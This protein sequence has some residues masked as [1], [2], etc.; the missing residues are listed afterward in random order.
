MANTTGIAA[1]PSLRLPITASIISMDLP[2]YNKRNAT[3]LLE[4]N[5]GGK[6]L[7]DA[8]CDG[9]KEPDGANPGGS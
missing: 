1:T 6:T 5:R 7:M 4:E 8:N 2:S 9:M 3:N